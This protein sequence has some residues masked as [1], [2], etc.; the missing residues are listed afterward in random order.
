MLIFERVVHAGSDAAQRSMTFK[1]TKSCLFQEVEQFLFAVRVAGWADT[2]NVERNIHSRSEFRSH[3][4]LVIDFLNIG[5]FANLLDF[6]L[7]FVDELIEPLR[8]FVSLLFEMLDTSHFKHVFAHE[9]GDPQRK[10]GRCVN[11]V[12]LAFRLLGPVHHQWNRNFGSSLYLV[13]SLQNF[14]FN[15]H[16]S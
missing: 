11:E 13:Y 7:R 9:L 6:V 4:V 12:I 2:V 1:S 15:N 5:V 10:H 3:H 14:I 8:L 16:E